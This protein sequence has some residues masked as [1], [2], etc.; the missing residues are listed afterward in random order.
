MS[1]Y[2]HR[3][4]GRDTGARPGALLALFIFLLVGFSVLNLFWPKRD[5]SELENRKLAQIPAFSVKALLNGTWFGDLSE[6]VQDQVAFRD[7]LIDLESAF[8]NL[9]FAK[10]EEGGILL[11]K[12]G[13]MFTKLFD[14]S[15]STQKQLDKNLQAVT[16]F[17]SRHPGKV[18]FLL[19]PSASVIYPEMLPAG[20]PMVDEN[21]L[22]DDI[23]AQVSSA[24]DVIDMRPVFTQ[25]K[26]QYLYY[27]TDHHWTT[28]GAYLAYEQF[29]QL[30]GLSPF[31]T[32]AYQAESVPGFY[33]THYSATR[34][35]NVQPDTITYYPL[36][37][38]MTI[39]DIGAETEYTPRTTESMINTEKFGTRDKYAAFLDGNNGYSVIEGNGE[40]SI[41][42]LKD[43]YANCFVPFLTA[44]YEKI[45]VVDLRNFSYGL[46]STIESEGYDQILILYN[47]QTFIADNR[48]VY[49]DRPTT[50]TKSE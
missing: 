44:N 32:N 41:L 50:L 42:V 11:G 16:S 39:F 14:I 36:D 23:F 40:G 47:F 27:K 30:K 1:R 4:A 19:A 8:N 37:N 24:A 28:Q 5:M 49:M 45:G 18:T 2:I 13:W 9:V 6:Y 38:P 26:E 35:W 25:Q 43:S 7:G 10:T 21:A 29:C 31:D 12:D 46:D 20:A 17:A 33:G 48:V 3:K 34:R 22:L 15:D